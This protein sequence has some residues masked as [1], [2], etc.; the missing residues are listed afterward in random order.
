[1]KRIRANYNPQPAFNGTLTCDRKH[2]W[3]VREFNP[4]R[5]TVTCPVCGTNT[6][7][8]KAKQ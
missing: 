7:I 1:M 3:D 8:K 6:D 2:R 4:E 5:K